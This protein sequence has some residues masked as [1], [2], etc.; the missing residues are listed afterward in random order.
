[1]SATQL[2]RTNVLDTSV[3]SAAG[4][5][6]EF[7][8]TSAKAA[9]RFSLRINPDLAKGKSP[10]AGFDLQHPI[11]RL[12]GND[13]MSMRLGPDEW[14]LIADEQDP[15]ELFQEVQQALDDVHRSLVDVS[16]RNIAL[17]LNGPRT[18]DVLN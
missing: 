2:Q 17:L 3:E 10:I 9:A 18:V 11:N 1:M 5:A 8:I 12:L 13:R 7:D 4:A 15:A 14:F 16:H 6:A